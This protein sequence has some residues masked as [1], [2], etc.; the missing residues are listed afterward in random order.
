ECV[1]QPPG[2]IRSAR[3][4]RVMFRPGANGPDG[5]PVA[6]ARF[7]RNDSLSMD[8]TTPCMEVEMRRACWTPVLCV[9]ITA[10]IPAAP[11]A[12]GRSGEAPDPDARIPMRLAA[13][14]R[15][16]SGRGLSVR[17]M[18]QDGPDYVSASDR[19]EPDERQDIHLA[20]AGLD[21]QRE[22]T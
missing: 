8:R 12:I 14:Q 3:A 21:P 22:I 17:W 15:G 18:G 19:H 1:R 9:A 11:P 4:S 7:E 5:C 20:L 10:L 13:Y 2:F 6:T 16:E